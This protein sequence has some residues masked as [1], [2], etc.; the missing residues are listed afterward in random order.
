[1]LAETVAFLSRVSVLL[2][3]ARHRNAPVSNNQVTYANLSPHE[4]RY[5]WRLGP[6]EARRNV[7]DVLRDKA[8]RDKG[9]VSRLLYHLFFISLKGKSQ[10]L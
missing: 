7:P 10:N 5:V 9:I 2:Q 3:M 4:V 1:M 8:V 6:L